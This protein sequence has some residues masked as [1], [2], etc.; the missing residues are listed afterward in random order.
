MRQRQ[1]IASERMRAAEADQV[2]FGGRVTAESGRRLKRTATMTVTHVIT[3]SG[4][5]VSVMRSGPGHPDSGRPEPS[6]RA[7]PLRLGH[8]Q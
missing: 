6:R 1:H 7:S 4:Q 5:Q 3:A 2:T 8:G